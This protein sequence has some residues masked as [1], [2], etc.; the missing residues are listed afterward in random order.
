MKKILFALF[1]FL[2]A[3][4]I[5][6]IS[7][8]MVDKAHEAAITAVQGRVEVDP[9]ANGTWVT[10]QVGIKLKENSGIRTGK[11]SSAEVVFDREGLNLIQLTE[12]TQ[13]SIHKNKIDLATG[14]IL[15][16]FDN[17]EPG[18]KFIIKTPDSSSTITGTTFRITYGQKLY[19]GQKEKISGI[20][21]TDKITRVICFK[22]SVSVQA[23][24]KNGRPMPGTQTI[25]ISDG[26]KSYIASGG[27]VSEIEDITPAEATAIEVWRVEIFETGKFFADV[28]D[29]EKLATIQDEMT[30]E[31]N[32]KD[33]YE[34]KEIS[35][36]S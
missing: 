27:K 3:L 30:D 25:T 7:Y 26:L 23:L 34:K 20:A 14:D 4:S 6:N 19:R 32:A 12:N 29:A 11:D 5:A 15:G 24:D 18:A 13:L 33:L 10:A 35:P 31:I 8:A 17:L 16:N 1:V 2:F 9:D 22:G 36:S 28:T 21:A